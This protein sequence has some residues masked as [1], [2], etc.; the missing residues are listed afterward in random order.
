MSMFEGGFHRCVV[1]E[2]NWYVIREK[3]HHNLT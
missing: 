2:R 3:K 1:N